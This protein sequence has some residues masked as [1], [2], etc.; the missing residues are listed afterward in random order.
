MK[1][2]FYWK[3]AF[4]NLKNNRRVYVPFLLS[5]IG[6]I[7]M[8]YIIQS[9]GLS[10]N[11]GGYGAGGLYGGRTI[12]MMLNLGSIVIGIFAVLFLFYTNSFIIKRRK[13][14][15]GLYNI[16]GME[17]F[18]IAKIIF[19][20]TVITTFCALALGLA[21]GILFSRAMFLLLQKLLGVD[22]HIAFTVPPE[23]LLI[24][25]VLFLVIFFLT[26]LYN[27][28]QVRLAK[29][30]ELLHGSSVGEKEP[31]AHWLLAILGI[32]C[33]GA[34]YYLAVTIQDP[35]QALLFFFI[36]VILVIFGT[37]LL[38]ITGITAFLK[39]LKKKKKFYYKA[40]HFT[41]VSGMLYRMK[42]NAAGLASICILFTCLLVTVST[43]L[44]LY[45]SMEDMI[46][47]RY[48]RD[49]KVSLQD[50]RGGDTSAAE[51]LVKTA[52]REESEKLGLTPVDAAENVFFFDN[53]LFRY[54]NQ[55][56][57]NDVTGPNG[58]Y[59]A[60][61]FCG[62]EDFNRCSGQ[63]QQ[64]GE[65]EV[66]LID[67]EHTFPE[68]DTLL[69]GNKEFSYRR[70]DYEMV[71]GSHAA[72]VA[73]SLYLIVPSPET[74]QELLDFFY[75]EP[76]TAGRPRYTYQFNV[77]DG[78]NEDITALKEALD[79]RLEAAA[80]D[81]ETND[82]RLSLFL[83]DV[84]SDTNS[85]YELYGGLFFLGIF[86]GLLFLMG[87]VMIIYYKQ[88]SEGYEDAK[89][90]SIMQKVGM[91]RKEVKKSIH[92]QILLVFFLPLVTAILHLCFA[93]PMLRKILLMMGMV[94]AW[95]IFFSAVG[96]VLV[97]GVIYTVIYAI[98]ARTYYKIVETAAE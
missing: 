64:L 23:A 18:H 85:F 10:I 21:L 8:F 83:E 2:G 46:R 33:L 81:S 35:V 45:T 78:T 52:V 60:V 13:K 68:G 63:N 9:I 90:F 49:I 75:D 88:V 15:L 61:T 97:F 39:L 7:M 76:G 36:A 54:G 55:L 94:N 31:K 44:A 1:R 57:W 96:C 27:I 51:E 16:L 66:L 48:P 22:L 17:K 69:L 3:L 84:A 50:V 5:S 70:L 92:S 20:E 29:P 93:Y 79:A 82:Y 86:L 30:I 74:I 91:S 26:M 89:R 34:G 6:I 62:L 25:A 4:Q 77:K 37:Y 12:T 73:E 65:N 11:P 80:Y 47:E 42:Q 95:M 98:T 38:F 43:T 59:A 53:V 14:E 72:V 58:S 67:P 19:R 87:T 28:L 24:T 32:A 71:D 40:N 41:T 56:L